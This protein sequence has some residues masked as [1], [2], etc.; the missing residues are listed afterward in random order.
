MDAN[1]VYGNKAWRQ[2]YKNAASCIEQI[3]ETAAHKAT[4]V[5]TPITHLENHQI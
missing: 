2:L 5:R 4:T 1:Q 3:L